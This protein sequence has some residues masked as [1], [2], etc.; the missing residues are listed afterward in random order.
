MVPLLDTVPDRRV[1]DFIENETP[2]LFPRLKGILSPSGWKPF[3]KEFVEIEE[4]NGVYAIVGISKDLHDLRI[5]VGQTEDQDLKTRLRQHLST[6]SGQFPSECPPIFYSTQRI[7]KKNIDLAEQ[8][9]FHLVPSQ[10][11]ILG[12]THPSRC[13]FHEAGFA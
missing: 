3:E 5:R 13:R 8:A 1:L 11:R 9:L 12:A 10:L 4:G 2:T 7:P 6:V